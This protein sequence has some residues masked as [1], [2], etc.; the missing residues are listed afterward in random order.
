MTTTAARFPPL[1][2]IKP[3]RAL[4]LPVLLATLWLGGRADVLFADFRSAMAAVM[5]RVPLRAPL[6]WRAAARIRALP[7]APVAAVRVLDNSVRAPPAA[8]AAPAT[9]ASAPLPPPAITGVAQQVAMVAAFEASTFTLAAAAAPSRPPDAGAIAQHGY[10]ALATGDR[11]TAAAD[12]ADAAARAP[13]DPRAP[14]WRREA[15][16]L[17]QRWS[18]SAYIFARAAGPSGFAS[19]ALLG[20]GQ[21]GATLAFTPAPLAARPLALTLRGAVAQDG[22]GIDTASAQG[23]LGLRWQLRPGVAVSAE[24]LV[25]SGDAAAS[26]WTARISGGASGSTARLVWRGYGEAGV[27]NAQPFVAGQ[28]F[29]GAEL[30]LHGV[31]AQ[32]GG[33]I[34][35]AVQHDGD[36]LGQ[37]DVG[38]SLRLH[39]EA[40]QLPVD[41]VLDYRVRV[42]GNARPGSGVAV[43]LAAWF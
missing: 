29:V 37:L 25:A 24:W 20:G 19:A 31:R 34:W 23:A 9:P 16:R 13:G 6:P 22:V 17:T 30:Q 10:D 39:P 26:G 38:P 18:G 15:D 41:I 36:T 28:G 42:A 43:T 27:V 1:A 4:A 3:L 40:L 5:V 21:S 11:R 2:T 32:A 14:A 8:I 33:G 12:F 35:G 7:P